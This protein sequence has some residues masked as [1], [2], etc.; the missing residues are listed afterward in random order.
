M[1]IVAGSLSTWQRLLSQEWQTP[2]T[3][4]HHLLDV[5]LILLLFAHFLVSRV[6][7]FRSIFGDEIFNGMA[8]VLVRL[9]VVLN[10]RDLCLFVE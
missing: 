3:I 9:S 10:L 8:E 1:E 2:D 6:N 4:A 7:L 5:L